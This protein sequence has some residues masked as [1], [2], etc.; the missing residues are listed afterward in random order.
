MEKGTED[1]VL[2]SAH[3]EEKRKKGPFVVVS[4]YPPSGLGLGWPRGRAG[5][6]SSLALPQRFL[7]LSLGGS[8]SPST[9][10]AAPPVREPFV[11][12]NASGAR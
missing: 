10:C 2:T 6:C 9:V 11:L 1:D 7:G 5:S 4:P 8:P 12:S 3:L